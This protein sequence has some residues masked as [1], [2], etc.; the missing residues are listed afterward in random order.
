MQVLFCKDSS[1]SQYHA[2]SCTTVLGYR[3]TWYRPT[4]RPASGSPLFLP[5][6]LSLILSPYTY[7][8]INSSFF[9]LSISISL[10]H[11]LSLPQ[12][13][14]L[15]APVQ[16]NGHSWHSLHLITP[17]QWGWYIVQL[18]SWFE[19]RIPIYLD[20]LVDSFL[21]GFGSIRQSTA[22][23]LTSSRNKSRHK[24]FQNGKLVFMPVIS[25]INNLILS[26][27]WT[28]DVTW[29]VLF[30]SSFWKG[31]MAFIQ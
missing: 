31:T 6:S 13:P 25:C 11:H 26:L 29:F 28:F 20:Y 2:V 18:P 27:W 4:Q 16:W 5:F 3:P 9:S 21:Y 12:H 22:S 1:S 15:S 24:T 30:L 23:F 8:T 19:F 14:F 10:H 17:A 7:I